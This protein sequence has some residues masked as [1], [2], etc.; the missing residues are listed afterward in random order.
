[1]G[2]TQDSERLM[3]IRKLMCGPSDPEAQLAGIKE[4][5]DE[6]ITELTDKVGGTGRP[7]PE[8]G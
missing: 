4:I 7:D 6:R 2:S 5:V 8:P 1:M 3:R